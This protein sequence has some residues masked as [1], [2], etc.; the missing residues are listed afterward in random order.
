VPSVEMCV[1]KLSQLYIDD[2]WAGVGSTEVTNCL[3]N[4][5]LTLNT[6][7]HPKF[8]GSSTRYYTS[9]E[10]GAITGELQLTLER[11]SGVA[12]EELKF[13]PA[14][15]YAQ[16]LRAVAIKLS[17]TQIGTG[18]NQTLELDCAGV[19]TSWQSLGAEEE[20]NSLDVVTLTFGYDTTGA[21][22]FQALV[23]TNVSAI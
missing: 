1:G 21:Q 12:T 10:Q 19:W 22:S 5:Q 16:T 23:T 11:T 7:A 20:G 14:S 3:I 6:G 18:D 15:G 13:R 2:T 9:H 17:G 8:W 4:W